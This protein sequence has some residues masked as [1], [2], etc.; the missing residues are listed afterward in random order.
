V[1][2][3]PWVVEDGIERRWPPTRLYRWWRA[4][5]DSLWR[6]EAEGKGPWL[7]SYRLP[8]QVCPRGCEY[9]E[10]ARRDLVARTRLWGRVDLHSVFEYESYNCPKCGAPL[11]R[12]C[13]RCKQKHL[14]PVSSLCRTCGLP[15]PWALE[16]RAGAERAS[17]RHWH[18]DV[19]ES[20]DPAEFL[21]GFGRKGDLWVIEGEIARLDVDAVVSNDDVEGQMWAQVARSIK[22]AAGPEVEQRAQDGRPYK[23]GQAWWTKPGDLVMDGIIH[24]ASMSRRGE[25]SIEIVRECLTAA[26]AIATKEKY[27]SIG[28]AAIGTGPEAIDP[29]VWNREFIDLMVRFLSNREGDVKQN[30]LSIVLVLFDQDEYAKTVEDLRGL[31]RKAWHGIASP[32][33]GYFDYDERPSREEVNG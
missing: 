12:R 21:Y 29:D 6:H 31:T 25:T 7:G 5:R 17:V 19:K 14:A 9:D 11:S 27:T 30:F 15:Q 24:V 28:I 23:L 10:L 16:R 20:N 22:V 4:R 3:A 33:A 8:V 13:V 26:L 2:E 32:A 1:N 18:P